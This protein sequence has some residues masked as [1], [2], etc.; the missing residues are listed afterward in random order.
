MKNSSFAEKLN[1]YFTNYLI[2]QKNYSID[3]IRSYK[4]TFK[5]LITYLIN[6]KNITIKKLSF[7]AFT[8]S[9]IIDFLNYLEND[10]KVS[11]TTRNQ[12]LAAIKSF[13]NYVSYEEINNIN[14]IQ[15]ILTIPTKK[16]AN[17]I[18]DY[19]TKDE[20]TKYLNSIS[21]STRKGIRDYTLILLMY[22]TAA[23]ANEIINIRINDFILDY[24]PRVTF[25]GKGK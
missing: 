10:L 25:Y 17:S 24:N 13:C 3:T 22:D 2:I 18:I 5:L 19:L 1:N 9:N 14:N 21:T 11:I 15:Q 8:R 7:D 20:L 12:R 16:G 4:T 6:Y 23:R